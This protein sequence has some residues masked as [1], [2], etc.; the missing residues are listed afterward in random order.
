MARQS[1]QTVERALDDVSGL[2]SFGVERH[3]VGSPRHGRDHGLAS[4]SCQVSPHVVGVIG[5][6]P[7]Q[8]AGG[9]RDGKEG[10][11]TLDVM[12]LACDQEKA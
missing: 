4:L 11:C 3:G 1:L 12:D 6:V 9:A 5:L 2:V 8:T 7:N 10:S